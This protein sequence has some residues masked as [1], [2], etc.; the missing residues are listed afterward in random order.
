MYFQNTDFIFHDPNPLSAYFRRLHISLKIRAK[1]VKA[2]R[3]K[4]CV[5]TIRETFVL[6]SLCKKCQHTQIKAFLC[7]ELKGGSKREGD[8]DHKTA[9][10]WV[11][12]YILHMLDKTK[13]F[14]LVK[15]HILSFMTPPLFARYLRDTIYISFKMRK[16]GRGHKK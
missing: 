8:C 10:I 1:R 4:K 15:I 9:F 5:F 16:K 6:S 2:I 12:W 11:L 13:V 14:Y 3:N 7:F